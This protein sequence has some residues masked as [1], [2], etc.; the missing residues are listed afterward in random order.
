VKRLAL[1]AL[2]LLACAA[3]GA[4]AQQRSVSYST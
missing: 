4:V 1:M 3:G 2:C